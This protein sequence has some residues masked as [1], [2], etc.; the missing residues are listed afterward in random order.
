VIVE[1]D[2]L[3]GDHQ[4]LFRHVKVDFK[5]LIVAKRT[6]RRASSILV[7]PGLGVILMSCP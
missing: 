5:P 1:S 3:N 7:V 4:L 2:P 6:D